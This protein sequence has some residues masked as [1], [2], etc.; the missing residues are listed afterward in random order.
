MELKS[1]ATRHCSVSYFEGG[2]GPPLVF[3]HGL[4]GVSGDDP[5]LERLA[6][7]FHV[8]APLIPGY[9]ESEECREIR[10]MLDFTLHT[11]DVVEALALNRPVLVGHSLGGMIASEM[12]AVA[13]RD[14]ASL[15]LLAPLGLW[16]DAH[17]VADIFATLPYEMPELL[18]HDVELGKAFLTTGAGLDDL[19]ALKAFFII[20]ARQLG[21]AGRLLFPIPDRG[22]AR[23]LYRIKA[24]TTV[25]WG[26]SDRLA[27]PVYA[28]EF[29]RG[30][31]G[32]TLR[33]I[34]EAGHMVQLEKPAETAAA[35]LALCGP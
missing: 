14:L 26:G 15:A 12:A 8:F 22:L 4:T 35:I 6:E 30:I 31:A 21:M 18:Y 16:L 29:A 27:P 25:I 33:I 34:R 23:R 28:E 10:D 3:L 20:N 24:K 2:S 9:G 13:P 1:I 5:F 19:D 17:P 7:H 32:S 11:W